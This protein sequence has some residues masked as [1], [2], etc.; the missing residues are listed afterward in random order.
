L[1]HARELLIP[2]GPASLFRKAGLCL[3]EK[4]EAKTF[5]CFGFD[6]AE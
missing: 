6:L 3:V 5:D 2:A 4:N 1:A